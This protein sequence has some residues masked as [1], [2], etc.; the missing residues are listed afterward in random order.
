MA[1][2]GCCHLFNYHCISTPNDEELI[3]MTV[4]HVQPAE[5]REGQGKFACFEVACLCEFPPYNS[6]FCSI[7]AVNL[8]Y[9][10]RTM[11]SPSRNHCA[12]PNCNS[13]SSNNNTFNRTTNGC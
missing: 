1:K 3:E 6:S 7:I 4:F 2:N 12:T 5:E 11:F 10:C 8:L 13:I 9:L